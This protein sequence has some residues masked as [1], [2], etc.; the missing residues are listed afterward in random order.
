MGDSELSGLSLAPSTKHTLRSEGTCCPDLPFILPSNSC[1]LVLIGLWISF[2]FQ[3]VDQQLCNEI[4]RTVDVLR[5]TVIEI[6]LHHILT[7]RPNLVETLT[8]GIRY[9]AVTIAMNDDGR[10]KY[11][12]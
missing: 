6:L 4:G 3:F 12:E 2:L 1:T 7:A 5:E 9:H 8:V 10:C 11:N